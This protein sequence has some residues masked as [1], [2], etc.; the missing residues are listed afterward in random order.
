MWFNEKKVVV[1]A[2]FTVNWPLLLVALIASFHGFRCIDV[3]L[4]KWLKNVEWFLI[5]KLGNFRTKLLDLYR[6]ASRD[7]SDQTRA[8]FFPSWMLEF[9]RYDILNFF[10]KVKN[11]HLWLS[12]NRSNCPSKNFFLFFDANSSDRQHR[13]QVHGKRKVEQLKIEQFLP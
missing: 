9:W 2:Y 4:M 8:F 10:L 12:T 5:F 13:E 11:T 1:N 3:L 7:I 6:V